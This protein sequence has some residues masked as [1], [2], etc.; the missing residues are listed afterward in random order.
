MVTEEDLVAR[1]RL[2]S[3]Q[4][5]PASV[6]RRYGVSPQLVTNVLSGARA[7]TPQLAEGMG[8]RKV[9]RFEPM[10]RGA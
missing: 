1:I 2:E 10:G 5:G 9:T 8:Y 6:A 7:V 3:Q 4:E